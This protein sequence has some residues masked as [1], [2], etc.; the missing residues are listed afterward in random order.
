MPGT[1]LRHGLCARASQAAH[2]R[3]LHSRLVHPLPSVMH[4]VG[5]SITTS[6]TTMHGFI[7]GMRMALTGVRCWEGA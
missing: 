5:Y 4:E 3:C 7:Q 2:H 6:S 1:S